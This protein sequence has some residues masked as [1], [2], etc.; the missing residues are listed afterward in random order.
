MLRTLF[1]AHLNFTSAL[2]GPPLQMRKLKLSEVKD[3]LKDQW[4]LRGDTG[5]R[6][7][8]VLTPETDVLGYLL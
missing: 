6:T 2:F 4:R 5:A 7:W 1:I 3:F 8:M